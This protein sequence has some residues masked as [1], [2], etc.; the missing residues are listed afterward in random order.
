VIN[1]K[2]WGGEHNKP[3]NDQGCFES[4]LKSVRKFYGVLEH[5]AFS[6]AWDKFNIPRPKQIGWNEL[7][8]EEFMCEVWQN[9]YGHKA[10]KRT[11]IFVKSKSKPQELFWDRLPGTHQIGFYDQRGKNKNKPTLSGKRASE[12]P[13]LF[14]K[15]LIEIAR[16][17]K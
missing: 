14:K 6:K 9:A 7:G 4:A 11:W 12:T 10:R 13:E 8:N 1:F 16:S 3:G 2:R 17:A 5:P 15:V